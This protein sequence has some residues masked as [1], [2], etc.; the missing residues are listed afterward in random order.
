[1]IATQPGCSKG[2]KQKLILFFSFPPLCS[3]PQRLLVLAH[4]LCPPPNS[5]FSSTFFHANGELVR[6]ELNF[7]VIVPF[8]KD[9]YNFP[10]QCPSIL[11]NLQKLLIR[12]LFRI[13]FLPTLS[14]NILSNFKSPF[15]GDWNHSFYRIQ[16]KIFVFYMV[17]VKIFEKYP[18]CDNLAASIH[19]NW[20]KTLTNVIRKCILQH[21][22]GSSL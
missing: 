9:F 18:S 4:A 8:R 11:E 6:A 10:K 14:M 7:H 16:V 19:Q 3:L 15:R 5:F 20:W 12:K 1:M 22:V 2:K 17:Q 13:H 21:S